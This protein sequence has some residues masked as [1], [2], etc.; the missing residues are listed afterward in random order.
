MRTVMD[1]AG[2]VIRHSW[3][4][5]NV[6]RALLLVG[7]AVCVYQAYKKWRMRRAMQRL[8]GKVVLI[9]GA[10][11]GLGEGMWSY[12]KGAWHLGAWYSG[13]FRLL[14]ALSRMCHSAG[15]KV[16]L[17]SR[18]VEQL[19][20]LKFQLDNGHVQKVGQCGSEERSSRGIHPLPPPPSPSPSSPP[21]LPVTPPRSSP[22]TSVTPPPSWQQ[23]SR[24]WRHLAI[25]TFW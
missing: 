19:Q 9:T 18:N 14:P 1:A 17:A 13:C 4:G 5:R 16:I 21:P 22:L 15:A 23:H 8:A 24:C 12:G 3:A 6:G 10:S 2:Y 20:R 11:S 7:L 25:L